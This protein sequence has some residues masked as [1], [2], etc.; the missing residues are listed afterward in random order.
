MT[1]L[2]NTATRTEKSLSTNG[3]LNFSSLCILFSS[4]DSSKLYCETIKNKLPLRHTYN[5]T[6]PNV[7]CQK[8]I[9]CFH[10]TSGCLFS[11]Q[12]S[13]FLCIYK[14]NTYFLLA[15]LLAC[16]SFDK[17]DT[18]S[19]NNVSLAHHMIKMLREKCPIKFCN[20]LD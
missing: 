12:S 16:F 19:E 9:N 20:N 5:T 2:G 3:T 13:I 14:Y 18:H 10:R 4:M 8:K 1:T 11:S 17:K 7:S 15:C 6:M